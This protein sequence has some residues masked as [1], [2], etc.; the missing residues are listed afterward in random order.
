[1]AIQ[2]NRRGLAS[3]TARSPR[4]MRSEKRGRASVLVAV[5]LCAVSF[6]GCGDDASKGEN[7]STD[8]GPRK[9]GDGG[10]RE[11]VDGG[12]SEAGGSGDAMRD[13]ATS[14]SGGRPG[15]GSRAGAGGRAGA[16][17]AGRGAAGAGGRAATTT[18]A[19]ECGTRTC[20]SVPGS[21]TRAC[22]ADEAT[23]TCGTSVMGRCAKPTTGT[24]GCPVF[25]LAGILMLPSC[26][27]STG[28]CGIDA[29]SVGG[30]GCQ[31][32]ATAADRARMAGASVVFPAP[33]A[34]DDADA[35]GQDDAGL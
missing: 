28:M 14:G 19:I 30:P 17:E 34:C 22:C 24:Q 29:T 12:S 31:D 23:S 8:G 16:G 6:A 9:A 25:D 15:A 35:G 33:R 32:L 27:T 3:M 26:C 5:L 4:G 2:L 20:A 11:A 10:T 21:F 7:R 1:M 18:T 13:A